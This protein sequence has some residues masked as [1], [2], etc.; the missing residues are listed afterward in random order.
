MLFPC[1]YVA[2]AAFARS[3]R[4]RY[5]EIERAE[6][7]RAR[8]LRSPSL[9]QHQHGNRL[10]VVVWWCWCSMCALGGVYTKQQQPVSQ[11]AVARATARASARLKRASVRPERNPLMFGPRRVDAAACVYLNSAH[12]CE[13]M[14]IYANICE[15]YVFVCVCIC[16][17]VYHRLTV[18]GGSFDTVRIIS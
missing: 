15:L 11:P 16:V 17:C 18:T 4:D 12:I 2:A 10:M 8:A 5:V 1:T 13:Y 3:P 6:F 14:Y 7:E 9:H